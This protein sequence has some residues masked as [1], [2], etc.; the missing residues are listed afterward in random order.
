MPADEFDQY[1]K[2][3]FSR[4]RVRPG[5]R[6]D[7][8]DEFRDHLETRLEELTAAGV[9]R[10]AAVDRALEEFGDAAGLASQMS[11]A[12]LLLARRRQ[13]KF[14]MRV[15]ASAAATLA[16]G[17]VVAYL[18][19]PPN[20]AVNPP[21]PAL[22]QEETPPGDSLGAAPR[23]P[24]AAAVSP[25]E[26]KIAALDAALKRP[27]TLANIQPGASLLDTLKAL[28]QEHG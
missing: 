13:R 6:S 8:A 2:T 11:H 15:T 25:D 21:G 18:F 1:L 9:P 28:E 12:F 19:A 22:A 17:I 14:L 20:R 7:L 26:Q 16:C 10:A 5:R 27:T 4:L 23:G 3:L 24:A